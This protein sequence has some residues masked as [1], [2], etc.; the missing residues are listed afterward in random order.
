LPADKVVDGLNMT[1][2]VSPTYAGGPIVDGEL[3]VANPLDAYRRGRWN[4]MPVLIGAT[5]ADGLF[6]GGSADQIFAPFGPRRAEAEALYNPA[7]DTPSPVYGRRALGDRTFLEPARAVA[8][9][10][11]KT[12]SPVRVFRFS[13][14]A[15]SRRKDW[16]GA[17]HATDVPFVFDTADIRYG[18]ALT[19]SDAATA[20]VAHAY[21]VRFAKTGGG[22]PDGLP[23]WPLYD[24]ARDEILDLGEAPKVMRDPLK[25]RLD[26]AERVND[27]R[28]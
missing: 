3:V 22:D 19:P 18:K 25:A 10:M 4:R 23:S 24:P 20:R 17:I 13:Y 6:R 8:R 14:V 28:P 9:A 15:E 16:W 26:L 5:D 7:G 11:A 12:G 1:T 27:A 2:M 21:W